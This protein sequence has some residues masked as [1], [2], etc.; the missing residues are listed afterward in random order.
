[1]QGLLG[2]EIAYFLIRPK[3]MYLF[4]KSIP[5]SMYLYEVAKTMDL[6]LHIFVICGLLAGVPVNEFGCGCHLTF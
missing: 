2:M 3:G 4:L 5:L 6:S 1:M